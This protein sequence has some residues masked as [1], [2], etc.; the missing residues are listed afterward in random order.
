M[1]ELFKWLFSRK[2]KTLRVTNQPACMF[3]MRMTLADAAAIDLTENVIEQKTAKERG[4]L[5]SLARYLGN[6]IEVSAVTFFITGKQHRQA[7]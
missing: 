2:T 4:R 1:T 5:A 7:P 6:R 3:C